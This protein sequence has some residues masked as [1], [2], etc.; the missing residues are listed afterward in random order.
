MPIVPLMSL[1]K[2]YTVCQSQVVYGRHLHSGQRDRFAEGSI[3]I[4][5]EDGLAGAVGRILVAGL[6]VAGQRVGPRAGLQAQD[7]LHRILEYDLLVRSELPQIGVER[8][9][10]TERVL[11]LDHVGARQVRGE[12]AP[13]RWSR[14][15]DVVVDALILRRCRR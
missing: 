15:G 8:L 12:S 14:V 4:R 9:A 13:G 3:R 6:V 11:R 7:Q 2:L 5:Q 10:G 1:L